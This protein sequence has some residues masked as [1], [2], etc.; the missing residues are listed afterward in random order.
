MKTKALFLSATLAVTSTFAQTPPPGVIS[1]P[2]LSD[3]DS[4]N[5]AVTNAPGETYSLNEIAAQLRQL[6]RTVN[7]TLPMLNAMTE[8]E[9]NSVAT[10]SSSMKGGIAGVLGS[11]LHSDTNQV[12]SSSESTNKWGNIL[13]GVL[14]TNTT[15]S[16]ST[17][18]GTTTLNDLVALRDQLQNLTP[19]LERLD[20]SGTAASHWVRSS[21]RNST[22][23]LAPT[24]RE[25]QSDEQ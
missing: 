25:R 1:R 13:R 18:S 24:G 12:A 8:T 6:H 16:A 4:G 20:T 11:I 19:I 5:L 7:Q 9:S 17:T 15:S 23:N 2:P 21:D 22:N 14:G 3:S 10:G